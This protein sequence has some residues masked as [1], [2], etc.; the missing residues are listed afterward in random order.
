MATVTSACVCRGHNIAGVTL[1]THYECKSASLSVK[2]SVK[3]LLQGFIEFTDPKKNH[4]NDWEMIVYLLQQYGKH[5]LQFTD[6]TS[7]DSGMYQCIAENRHGVIHA[8]AELRV[9]GKLLHV[10]RRWK[11]KDPR[12][13]LKSLKD[14]DLLW[15]PN[16]LRTDYF[17]LHKYL[18]I[19]P[20]TFPYL[21]G[22]GINSLEIV[23]HESAPKYPMKLFTNK[24]M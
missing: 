15:K 21:A 24:K 7:D 18:P 16:N 10:R 13:F 8:N 11:D 6:V 9:F 2:L 3:T 19:P 20:Q 14:H 5:E 22:T 1:P 17:A 4:P 12:L 23:F